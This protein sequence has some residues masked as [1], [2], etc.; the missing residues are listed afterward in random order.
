MACQW[1]RAQSGAVNTRLLMNG[2]GA[3]ALSGEQ[4]ITWGRLFR[5]FFM[6]R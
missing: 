4:A 6:V 1:S 5:Q 2:P 3:Y